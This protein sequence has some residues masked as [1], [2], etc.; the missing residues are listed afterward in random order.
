[1][2]RFSTALMKSPV[3]YGLCLS[4]KDYAATLARIKPTDLGHKEFLSKGDSACC[5]FI[6]IRGGTSVRIVVCYRPSKK[7]IEEIHADLIHEAVHVW[8]YIRDHIGEE[9]AGDEQEAYS[10][11]RIAFGLMR[12]YKKQTSKA[13]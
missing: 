10:I 11:E 7:P 2:T 12:S 4:A 9:K 3:R 13:P 5:K 6:R 1:M 8:Q